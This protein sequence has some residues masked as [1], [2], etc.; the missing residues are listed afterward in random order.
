[1]WFRD[2]IRNLIMGLE[3]ANGHLAAHFSD[4]EVDAYRAG[5][6]AALIAMGASCGVFFNERDLN[7][8]LAS[9]AVVRP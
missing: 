3:L 7:A 6:R 5:Y 2:D 1:M 4:S 9:R 8:V